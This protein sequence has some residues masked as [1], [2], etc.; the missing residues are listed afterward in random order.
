MRDDPAA[1][2]RDFKRVTQVYLQLTAD[3]RRK[4]GDSPSRRPQAAPQTHA[5]RA[6]Q[7]FALELFAGHGDLSGALREQGLEV[8]AP[9]G[10]KRLPLLDLLDRRILQE[11]CAWIKR[12]KVWLVHL[13][14]PGSPWSAKDVEPGRGRRDRRCARVTVEIM[15][16]CRKAGV[17]VSLENPSGSALWRWEP[18]VSELRLA[19]CVDIELDMCRFGTPYQKPTRFSSN[20]PLLHGELARRCQCS[21]LHIRLQGTVTTHDGAGGLETHWASS[22]AARYPPELC[23][24]F[25]RAAARVAPD[26]ARCHGRDPAWVWTSQALFAAAGRPA[27]R[28]RAPQCPV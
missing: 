20:L 4:F 7:C 1:R 5:P 8:G 9:V 28:A 10:T 27:T 13:G 17:F 3:A 25:A 22:F 2:R 11:I 6:T 12:G 15:R 21:G 16:A 19:D 24:A 23:R 14:A 26:S 18:L